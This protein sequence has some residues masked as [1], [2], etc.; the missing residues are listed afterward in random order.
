[1]SD[2]QFLQNPLSK[3]W[4]ILAPR[5]AKRP[6]VAVG[7]EPRCPFCPGR[8]G[9]EPEIY[10]IGGE[11]GDSNWQVRVLN[12][13]YPFAPIHEIIIHSQDHHK[14]FD[15]LSVEQTKLIIET[16]VNRYKAHQD[17][18]QVYIF[19][20][21]GEKGGESLPHPHTQIAVVPN[22]VHVDTPRLDP[23]ATSSYAPRPMEILKDDSRHSELVS[24]SIKIDSVQTSHFY[25]F[26]PLT[27]QWPDEVWVA[28]KQKGRSFSEIT[29]EEIKDFSK[30]LQRLIQIFDLRHGHD[31]PFNFYIYPGGDWY[32]RLIPR[33]KVIGGFELST[34]IFINTQDPKETIAFIKEHFEEP[35]IEKIQGEHQAE[36]GKAA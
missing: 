27:S 5:R 25:L 16:Y 1:M 6:N 14:N 36:Y 13:K 32:L 9:E 24:E 26:C 35:N 8:E 22:K 18:G 21:R 2:F 12:N 7:M 3:K 11:P 33:S 15:E 31:F 23:S 20:N 28:P 29:E 19:H 4:V 34:G 17:K 30:I 10:R